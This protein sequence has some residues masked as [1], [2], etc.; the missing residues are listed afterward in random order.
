MPYAQ[1]GTL[2]ENIAFH[3]IFGICSGIATSEG[4]FIPIENLHDDA[5]GVIVLI[6]LGG[7]GGDSEGDG[8][9]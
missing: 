7:W 9:G 4:D 1:S 8:D 6:F 3:V 2:I 5:F